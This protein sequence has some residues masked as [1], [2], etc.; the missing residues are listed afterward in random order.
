MN[1]CKIIAEAGTCNH[2][3]LYAFRA[4]EAIAEAGAYAMKVQLLN[5]DTLTSKQALSYGRG[6]KEPTTQ[7]SA[8][9]N[10]LP[11]SDWFDLRA[12][13][14]EV[15]GIE[16]FAS[17]WDHAAVDACMDMG[18]RWFKVG[19][20]DI[21]YESLLRYIGQTGVPVMLS[22]GGAT[23]DEIQRAFEWIGRSGIVPFVC[24]L[25]YPCPREEAHL[26][27]LKWWSA[28]GCDVGYSDHTTGLD[29]VFV[30]AMLGAGFVEKHFT[31]TPGDGGDHDFGITPDQLEWVC[32]RVNGLGLA[33]GEFLRADALLGSGEIRRLDVEEEAVES[34]RRSWHTVRG[35]QAGD[36]LWSGGLIAL[37]P[38]TG[39]EP[40]QVNAERLMDRP[41][42]RPYAAGEIIDKKELS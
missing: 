38:G 24:T 20:A 42:S 19:S 2:D 32:G 15:L 13:C 26:N 11:Y 39:L 36:D 14:D 8:F 3:M 25:S 16:W 5:P 21:T 29:T 17:C 27:R 30:A 34:A 1:D 23:L 22:T 33:S 12:Y 7:H 6:L 41:A 37:R 31:V 10:A 18:V 9:K 4:A 35:V 28:L 40:T